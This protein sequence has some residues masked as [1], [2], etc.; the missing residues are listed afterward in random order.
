[1]PTQFVKK[2]AVKHGKSIDYM[3]GKW[4]KAKSIVTDQYGD[5]END[6]FWLLTTAIFKKMIGETRILSFTEFL[7]ERNK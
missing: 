7:S 6:R 1:M 5:E 2:M 4:E 3:E